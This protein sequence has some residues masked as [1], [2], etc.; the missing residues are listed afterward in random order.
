MSRQAAENV[1]EQTVPTLELRGQREGEAPPL[2]SGRRWWDRAARRGRLEKR[3]CSRST[4]GPRDHPCFF[5]GGV[6]SRVPLACQ[7]GSRES[8]LCLGVGSGE[9][10]GDEYRT[11]AGEEGREGSG[12]MNKK[13][14]ER[15]NTTETGANM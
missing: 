10:G 9:G 3:T 12:E 4:P 15:I 2:W 14:E 11:Q 8:E 13:E 1:R 6:A 7:L 5:L